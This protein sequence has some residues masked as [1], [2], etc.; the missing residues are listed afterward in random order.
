MFH[1]MLKTIDHRLMTTDNN[2]VNFLIPYCF[3]SLHLTCG[4]VF[5]MKFRRLLPIVRYV[6]ITK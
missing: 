6:Q 3:F 1:T 4:L 2:S 5:G